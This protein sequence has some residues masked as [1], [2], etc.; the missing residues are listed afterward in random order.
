MSA[1]SASTARVASIGERRFLG[2]YTSVAYSAKAADI[3]LLRRK[4]AAVMARAGFLPKSH[5]AKALLTILEQFPRDL[6]FQ[7]EVEDLYP[8]AIGILRLG[9]RQRT[10]LFVHSDAY[11]RFAV[12]PG[13]RAARK[14][15]HR[16]P[17][18]R[19]Q[20]LLSEALQR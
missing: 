5:A 1:S 9:E 13:L 8:T 16:H 19:I 7:I 18:S 12:V 4:V 15:Q 2:L 11:G 17:R 6:L 3:P 20:A 10:R 14:L